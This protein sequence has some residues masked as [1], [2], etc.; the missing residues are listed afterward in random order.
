MLEANVDDTTG[1]ILAHA[2][3]QALDAGAMAE[4]LV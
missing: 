3:A 4:R 1:E 2:V